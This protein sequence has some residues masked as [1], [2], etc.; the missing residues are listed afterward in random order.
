MKV[1]LT[2]CAVCKKIIAGQAFYDDGTYYC[3]K[4][5][6]NQIYSSDE[7]NELCN[8]YDD[9]CYWT[10]YER[11]ETM[12]RYSDQKKLIRNRFQNEAKK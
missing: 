11:C 2:R 1:E 5:C 8:E 3:S 10:T 4:K 7:W 12:Y 6:L 9:C